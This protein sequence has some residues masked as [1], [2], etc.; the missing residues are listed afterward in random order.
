[1]IALL[2]WL[3]AALVLLGVAVM[4]LGTIG[5]W[6]LPDA[7]SR[8]HALTKADHAGLGLLAVGLTLIGRDPF[9]A[10]IMALVWL[11]IL[12]SGATAAQLLVADSHGHSDEQ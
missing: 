4:T 6:R 9:A 3:G 5:L 7:P 8:L 11:L 10:L 1:M 12:L 2:D